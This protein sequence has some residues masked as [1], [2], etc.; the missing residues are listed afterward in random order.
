MSWISRAV[1]LLGVSSVVAPLAI[2]VAQDGPAPVGE[3][4]ITQKVTVKAGDTD[5]KK[6]VEKKAVEKK[7]D[8]KKGEDRK[9]ESKVEVI[10]VRAVAAPVAVDV[11]APAPVMV[12][13]NNNL[14][15][16]INQFT[17]QFR[18]V[19]RTELHFIKSVCAPTTEQQKKI[20]REG[21]KALSAAVKKYAQNQ[22]QMMQGQWRGGTQPDPR[23]LVQKGLL[24]A[25]K[26]HLTSEQVARYEA[27]IARRDADFQVV[28][29]HNIVC[30]LDQE[31]IL[32]A[33]QREKL[34]EAMTKGWQDSWG[35]SLE[36]F[37]YGNEYLPV[38]PD[39][40]VMPILDPIQKKV[41]TTAQKT[42]MN[43]FF[44]GMGFLGGVEMDA[45][46]IDEAVFAELKKTEEAEAK[47]REE[48]KAKIQGPPKPDPQGGNGNLV[49]PIQV[50]QPFF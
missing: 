27:E 26:A 3:V 12:A 46:P 18:P 34:S 40:I 30:K 33:E 25:A 39:K 10:E 19:L 48:A 50:G 11:V 4:V 45:D 17:Q 9:A 2:V 6:V 22:Q 35:G 38:L 31:L 32:T 21:H 37:M 28:A 8:E 15:P 5:G 7:G 1:V 24:E 47:A 29:V 44:N 14:D 23:K 20:A 49:L 16:L 13:Q 43:S 36:M 41:W 42:Q